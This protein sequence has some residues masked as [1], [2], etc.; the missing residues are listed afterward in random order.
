MKKLLSILLAITML[1][2]ICAAASADTLMLDQVESSEPIEIVF[3]NSLS[4]EMFDAVETLV[5]NYNAS[6][7][8][9][10]VTSQYQGSYDETLV[11]FKA[12]IDSKSGPDVCHMNEAG[13]RYMIDSGYTVNLQQYVDASGYDLNQIRVKPRT[14][15]TV[16][17][18]LWSMPFNY[19]QCV[20]FYNKTAFAEAGLD[21]ENPPRTIADFADAVEKLTVKD[22]NGNIVRYG[23]SYLVYGWMLEQFI[24]GMGK[25]YVNNNNGRTGVATALAD[26]IY[27]TMVKIFTEWNN[28]YHVDGYVDYGALNYAGYSGFVNG[29]VCM[30]PFVSGYYNYALA[31]INNSFEFGVGYMPLLDPSEEGGNLLAGASLWM[32]DNGDDV[33]KAASWDFIQYMASAKAQGDWTLLTGDIAINNG[34]YEREDVKAYVDANAAVQVSLEQETAYAD[35]YYT[36]GAVFGVMTEARTLF[37]ENMEAV[38]A[39]QKTPEQ[40]ANDFINTINDSMEI[41]GYSVGY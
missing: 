13:M 9:V 18:D 38:F 17:G 3:W 41:Y 25:L 11:K 37:E 5:A 15:Y 29:T 21:P 33:K 14:Y 16:E 24:S 31:A 22:A 19:G 36:Q 10:H 35:N 7:N 39:G 40:A 26:D 8:R 23:G 12:S 28:L 32:V 34:A 30:Y 4:G 27:D 2:S 20:M 6:Q 1:L